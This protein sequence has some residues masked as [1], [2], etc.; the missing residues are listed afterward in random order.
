MKAA[1]VILVILGIALLVVGGIV[2]LNDVK[3]VRYVGILWW[4]AGAIII[5]DGIL[6]FAVAGIGI[7]MRRAGRV[8][9]VPLVAVIIVQGALAI[10]ALFALIVVPEILK[11]SIGTANPTLLPLDYGLHLAVFYGVLA[12]ATAVAVGGYLVL[13]RRQNVRPPSSQA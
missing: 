10:A 7:A 2:L 4:F 12:A 8:F 9:R 6:A 1:R 5:H 13:A 3:P 11:K